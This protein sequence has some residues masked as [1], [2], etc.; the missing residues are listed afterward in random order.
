MWFTLALYLSMAVL[1]I[2]LCRLARP[3]RKVFSF[4]QKL[5]T[6]ALILVIFAMGMKIGAD[7]RVVT[8]LHTIGMKAFLMTFAAVGGSILFVHLGRR[9]MRIDGRGYRKRD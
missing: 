7:E 1:G 6:A 5:Q 2:V 9:L 8:S 3:G 4:T